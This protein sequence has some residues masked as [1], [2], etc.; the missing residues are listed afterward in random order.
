MNNSE[1]DSMKDYEEHVRSN[2]NLRD[3]MD[4]RVVEPRKERSMENSTESENQRD[5]AQSMG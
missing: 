2:E 1:T 3:N 4:G 5:P